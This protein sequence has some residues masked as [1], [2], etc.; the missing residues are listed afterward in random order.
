M[1]KAHS[2]AWKQAPLFFDL[3]IKPVLKV[4]CGRRQEPLKAFADRWGWE[5]TECD[6]KKVVRRDDIDI[7]DISVPTYLHRDIA[8]EAIQAGK[9]IFCEKPIA[10]DLA[11]I[12]KALAAVD[13]AGVKLQIG[14]NRRFDPSFR[15]LREMV[16]NGDIG[17][18]HILHITSRD[19]APPPINYVKVSGGLFLDMTIHDFDMARFMIGDEVDEIYVV[20]GVMVDEKIGEAGDID[21][22]V[23]TLRFRNGA[24]GIIDNSRKAVYGYDQR[25]EVFCSEG[26]A[27]AENLATDSV[28][29]SGPDCIQSAKPPRFFM[30]RYTECYI[31]EFREFI[32][33]ALNGKASLVTGKD[34]R[35][36]VAVAH[37]AIKSWKENRPV[38]IA[39]I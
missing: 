29:V 4:V 20:G 13:K 25:L 18:P 19:P 24:M 14:F 17:T 37:A 10:P 27:R 35:M 11:K 30:D 36:A 1:G 12:D 26:A 31:A 15:R 9:H 23:I 3:P 16:A 34:G 5:H 7:V 33:C 6:W 38:K 32:D 8:I 28:L 21:T 39:E 22:A 2:N